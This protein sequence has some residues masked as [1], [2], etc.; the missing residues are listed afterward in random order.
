MRPASADPY[1]PALRDLI[2][3]AVSQL[4]DRLR[5]SM[6]LSGTSVLEWM[7]Q[8]AGGNDPAAYYHHLRGSPMFVF[9]WA[10]E[11]ALN[12]VPDLPAQFD[13]VYSTISGYYWVRLIDNLTDH[14]STN[15]L[16]L[17]PALGLFHTEFQRPYQARFPAT[18]PFWEFFTATWFHSA[19][20]T[21]ADLHPGDMEREQF[22]QVAAQKICA[23]KI[24]L[25]ALCYGYDRPGLLPEWS[26]FIDLFGCW[27]Q[28]SNDL[29]H[30]YED[31][32]DGT[33]TYLLAEA[34]RCKHRAETITDW[35]VRKGFSW[36]MGL[37][38]AWM[39]DLQRRTRSMDSRDLMRYL[40]FRDALLHRDA[41][42][43][44]EAL[45]LAPGITGMFVE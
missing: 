1:D 43:T 20:V 11:K 36:A 19:D 41:D 7:R 14:Q 31:E 4:C 39:Y 17:L 9:P 42:E 2:D 5:R 34:E 29:F 16:D 15:E 25:A 44:L 18:H 35:V 45:R 30:W 6:P 3:A 24:P 33:L 8:L 37:L 32:Q 23:I 21:M 40:Q 28:M 38:D 12:G 10:L 13:L 27:H 22:V 26:S